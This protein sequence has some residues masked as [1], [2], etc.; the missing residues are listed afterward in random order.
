M[1][2]ERKPETIMVPASMSHWMASG[3]PCAHESDEVKAPTAMGVSNVKKKRSSAVYCTYT[4]GL[5]R[6]GTRAHEGEGGG[7]S[8]DATGGR[9]KRRNGMHHEYASGGTRG[10]YTGISL[11]LMA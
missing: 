11:S 1:A 5:A 10:A 6:G 7:A 3:R 9:V 8:G 4:N 2:E